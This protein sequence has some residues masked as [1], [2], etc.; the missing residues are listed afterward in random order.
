MSIS[1]R[2]SQRLSIPPER[3]LANKID[4]MEYHLMQAVV[5]Q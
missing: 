3:T 5:P 2:P 4:Q 1:D